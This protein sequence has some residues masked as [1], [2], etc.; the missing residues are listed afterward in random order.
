MKLV[1]FVL[2]LV[3]FAMAGYEG[4]GGN[5]VSNDYGLNKKDSKIQKDKLGVDKAYKKI[6]KTPCPRFSPP[7][8]GNGKCSN[9]EK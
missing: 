9:E 7:K 4:E 2:C 6:K 5:G 8:E 3:V 1:L